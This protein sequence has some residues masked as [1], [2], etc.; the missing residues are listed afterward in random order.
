M[1]YTVDS[2]NVEAFDQEFAALDAD[3]VE[4]ANL[5]G[6]FSDG[7]KSELSALD[8][9]LEAA[10]LGGEIN[11]QGVAPLTE[12]SVEAAFV[13]NF[14]KRKAE[15]LIRQLYDYIRRYSKCVK[16]IGS[17]RSAVS[18]YKAGNYGSAIYWAMETFDCVRDCA[19]H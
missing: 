2:F 6:D 16:C 17:L 8:A 5:G 13:S 18:A 10:G 7:D 9:D 14:L 3:F 12:N 15:R 19:G 1:A 4:L 11:A